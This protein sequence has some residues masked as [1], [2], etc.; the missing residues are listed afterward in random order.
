MKKKKKIKF[1]NIE[2][3][4]FN[5]YNNIIDINDKNNKILSDM[6]KIKQKLDTTLF[7][8]NDIK[9]TYNNNIDFIYDFMNID[10]PYYKLYDIFN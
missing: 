9:D 2:D 8:D 7:I 4:L 3:Y 6:N 10:Y 1:N 5:S